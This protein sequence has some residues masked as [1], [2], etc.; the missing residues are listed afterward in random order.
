MAQDLQFVNVVVVSQELNEHRRWERLDP[1]RFELQVA[2]PS[3]RIRSIPLDDSDIARMLGSVSQ[4][5]IRKM[6][7]RGEQ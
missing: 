6:Q 5:V 7:A 3:G 2:T 4:I 1:P